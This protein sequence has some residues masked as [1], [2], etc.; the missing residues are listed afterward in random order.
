[1]KGDKISVSVADFHTALEVLFKRK[2]YSENQLTYLI[3]LRMC[4]LEEWHRKIKQNKWGYVSDSE[5]SDSEVSIKS[6]LVT[7]VIPTLDFCTM[8]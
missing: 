6:K 5:E 7:P 8:A 2:F 4:K 1:M 3:Y